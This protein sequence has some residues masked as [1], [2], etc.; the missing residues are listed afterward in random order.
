L[1]LAFF[2]KNLHH[3]SAN[4]PNYIS[5]TESPIFHHAL[6]FVCFLNH[7]SHQRQHAVQTKHRTSHFFL[8]YQRQHV[9]LHVH[10]R[11]G[12]AYFYLAPSSFFSFFKIFIYFQPVIT[13]APACRTTQDTA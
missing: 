7:P 1:N 12:A 10:A 3:F 9:A 4:M 11:H 2:L 6:S 13:S 8:K 5:D